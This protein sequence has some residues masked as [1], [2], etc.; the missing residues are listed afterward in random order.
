MTTYLIAHV[1]RTQ[2]AFDIA[3]RRPCAVCHA[4]SD[5]VDFEVPQTDDCYE[6][7]GKGY[8]WIIPTSGYRA[9][10]YADFHLDKLLGETLYDEC[11]RGVPADWPD[12]YAANDRPAKP[13]PADIASARSLL[14]SL[15]LLKPPTS[16]NRRI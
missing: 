15:G 10:P 13:S 12:H 14:E 9:R 4:D 11:I 6:C 8:W 16:I 5:V 2:P 1:V 7:N 3:E